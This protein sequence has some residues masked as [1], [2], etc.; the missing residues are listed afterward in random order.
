MLTGPALLLAPQVNLFIIVTM[1]DSKR[2]EAV[3]VDPKQPSSKLDLDTEKLRHAL[4]RHADERCEDDLNNIWQFIKA[5]P[6]FNKLIEPWNRDLCRAVEQDFYK[7]G[8]FVC[9]IGQTTGRLYFILSGAVLVQAPAKIPNA[10]VESDGLETVAC[11]KKG[12]AFGEIE[13]QS[14]KPSTKAFRIGDEP[15][16]LAY[17][18]REDFAFTQRRIIQDRVKFLRSFACVEDALQ[19]GLVVPNEVSNMAACLNEVRLQNERVAC[20]QGTKVD[21]M[22]FIRAGRLAMV[23]AV[24]LN[25]EIVPRPRPKPKLNLLELERCSVTGLTIQ[26]PG[27]EIL[28]G[29][30]E[31]SPVHAYL[32]SSV[33]ESKDVLDQGLTTV[34]NEGVSEASAAQSGSPKRSGSGSPK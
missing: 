28:D 3:K 32:Q 10:L 19:L 9:K 25:A 11:L 14:E 21:R 15:T 29:S 31:R 8:D 27:D 5:C 30:P 2:R 22:I 20:Q 13:S 6:C 18:R 4:K 16:E 12:S 1:R 24:D 34:A 26:I 17:V 7:P 23:R 33:E